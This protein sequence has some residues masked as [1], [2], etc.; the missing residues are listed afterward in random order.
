MQSP[1]FE[2]LRELMI[3]RLYLNRS[4]TASN[5]MGVKVNL[6]NANGNVHIR[7]SSLVIIVPTDVLQP[8]DARP[9]AA[10]TN[11]SDLKVLL[12]TDWNIDENATNLPTTFPNVFSWMKPIVFPFKC[13]WNVFLRVRNSSTL[14]QML[15]WHRISHNQ[16]DMNQ[17]EARGLT[18]YIASLG[19]NEFI[20]HFKCFIV[21]FWNVW[22][23]LPRT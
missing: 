14:V 5:L 19:H 6:Q 7:D 10:I 15:G 3:G 13:L 22:I 11:W 17:C 2:T 20:I 16:Y 23:D 12:S 9:S 8:K 4:Q 21:Q 1:R 18:P